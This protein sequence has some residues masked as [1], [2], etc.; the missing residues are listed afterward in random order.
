M[1]GGNP[2]SY[3]LFSD[4]H[5]PVVLAQ[6][7]QRG[8]GALPLDPGNPEQPGSSPLKNSG[9]ISHTGILANRSVF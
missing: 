7:P 4:W 9:T 8:I 2:Q 5:S 3:S 6:E 1:L